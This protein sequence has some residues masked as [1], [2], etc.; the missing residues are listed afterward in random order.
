MFCTVYSS[1]LKKHHSFRNHSTPSNGLKKKPLV[2]PSLKNK[3]EEIQ[4]KYKTMKSITMEVKKSR[5]G[6]QGW[7]AKPVDESLDIRQLVL[8]GALE[9]L[10]N[11]LKV[12]ELSGKDIPKFVTIRLE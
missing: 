6:R 2:R 5:F 1:S 9:K 12:M 3:P 11:D 8:N 4:P 7:I 10:V